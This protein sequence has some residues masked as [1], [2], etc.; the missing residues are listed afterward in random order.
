MKRFDRI[1]DWKMFSE[2]MEQHITQYATPQYFNAD[3]QTDQ[4]GAWDSST[5][6]ENMRRYINRAGKNLRGPKEALRDMLKI[7]HYA[8]FAY[9]K[10]KDEL[11]EGDVYDSEP[12]LG[13]ILGEK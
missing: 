4:V 3:T 6:I 1:N 10:L 7:A 9:D 5:C 13:G 11:G 2:Q 8:Q 12:S